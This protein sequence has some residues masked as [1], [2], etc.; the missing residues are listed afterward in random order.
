MFK[1]LC[2]GTE[3]VD[4]N[5]TFIYVCISFIEIHIGKSYCRSR[6]LQLIFW[7]KR[8]ANVATLQA[9]MN[10]APSGWTASASDTW[11]TPSQTST[12]WNSLQ[13]DSV[14][15]KMSAENPLTQW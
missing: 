10:A 9:L 15:Q 6:R 3:I 4:E 8:G 5:V 12:E 13:D 11:L 1:R 2:H 7:L 14:D